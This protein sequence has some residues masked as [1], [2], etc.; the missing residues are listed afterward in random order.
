MINFEA[1]R[2]TAAAFRPIYLSIPMCRPGRFIG[3]LR[4]PSAARI[5]AQIMAKKTFLFK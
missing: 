5:V 3:S 2:G 1:I 4:G